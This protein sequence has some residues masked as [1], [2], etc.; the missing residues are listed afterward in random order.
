MPRYRSFVPS[1]FLLSCVIVFSQLKAQTL[2]YTVTG[3]GWNG[4][5][6]GGAAYLSVIDNKGQVAG[7]GNYFTLCCTL[8][9]TVLTDLGALI[10]GGSVG[11]LRL[12]NHR[13]QPGT[14]QP[15]IQI[16]ILLL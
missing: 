7:C 8:G 1:M 10:S 2:P 13:Q 4:S 3:L 14:R 12:A 11:Y 9:G 5:G 6:R 16:E 15:C